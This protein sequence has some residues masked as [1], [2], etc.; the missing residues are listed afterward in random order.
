MSY[1]SLTRIGALINSL[2]TG[3]AED[4]NVIHKTLDEEKIG[5]LTVRKLTGDAIS[6]TKA[7]TNNIISVRS[8]NFNIGIGDVADVNKKLHVHG[9]AKINGTLEIAQG[10]AS[11]HALRR[12]ELTIVNNTT[13]DLS[14]AT[15]NSTYPNAFPGFEVHCKDIAIGG[16]TIYKKMTTTWVILRCIQAT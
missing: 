16:P 5:N 11:T 14:L 7:D 4:N 2:I 3:K 9:T 15:L 13:T 12:D 1:F 8:D 6:A 10:T